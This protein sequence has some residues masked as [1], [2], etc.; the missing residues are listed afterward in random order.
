MSKKDIQAKNQANDAYDY[1]LKLLVE[2]D[3]RAHLSAIFDALMTE[4]EQ[5]ELANRLTIFALLQQGM[6][7]REISAQLGVGIA[8]VSRGAKVFS[9]HQ[10]DELLPDIGEVIG[11]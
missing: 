10:I 1:L 11:I 5:T 9:Q 4:K 6:T 2:T 8:T 3:D 7:Q